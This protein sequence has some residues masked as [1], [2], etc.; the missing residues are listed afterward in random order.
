MALKDA[1][2]VFAGL[3]RTKNGWQAEYRN[4]L[5]AKNWLATG[6]V[7]PDDVISMLHACRES[8][9]RCYA[10]LDDPRTTVHDF[11]PG[12]EGRRWIIKGYLLSGSAL[13]ISV[14]P[15]K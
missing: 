6:A 9:Y 13:F 10:H 5:A 8:Q 14:H 12:W 1:R 3:L 4:D 11:R 7:S 15:V 2:D